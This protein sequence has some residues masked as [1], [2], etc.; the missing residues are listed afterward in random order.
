MIIFPWIRYVE[1]YFSYAF[2]WI[3]WKA[4]DEVEFFWW[5]YWRFLFPITWRLSFW[6]WGRE[7]W[8]GLRV[9]Y[10][11]T[12]GVLRESLLADGLFRSHR[13][14]SWR[15]FGI[16]FVFD[17]AGIC[18]WVGRLFVEDYLGYLG[19]Q[20]TWS[21]V[22][23]WFLHQRP[24]RRPRYHP[25]SRTLNL[26]GAEC[27][28]ESF[29]KTAPIWKPTFLRTGFWANQFY[30]PAKGRFVRTVPSTCR[31]YRWLIIHL[32]LYILRNSS[33]CFSCVLSWGSG[34]FQ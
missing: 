29:W 14:W 32:D 8:L 6:L 2:G 17:F 18:G 24:L 22:L 33:A 4:F 15:S 10:W 26:F 3:C 23:S 13:S 7:P 11:T 1:D 21:V 5:F 31:F 27:I 20:E 12:W 28:G 30:Y 19:H 25:R 34:C 16:F 9:W